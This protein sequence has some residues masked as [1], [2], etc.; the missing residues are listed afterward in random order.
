MTV[1]DRQFL[2]G[3]AVSDF[4]MLVGNS[5]PMIADTVVDEETM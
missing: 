1:F 3:F 4:Y 5:L 2:A